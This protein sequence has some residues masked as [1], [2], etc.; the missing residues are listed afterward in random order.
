MLLQLT[1]IKNYMGS[2]I[3]CLTNSAQIS[4]QLLEPIFQKKTLNPQKALS[5]VVKIQS[6]W[7]GS[8]VRKY[9]ELKEMPDYRTPKSRLAEEQMESYVYPELKLQGV[10]CRLPKRIQDGGVYLGEMDRQEAP[11]ERNSGL[12]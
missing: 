12:A 1:N 7:R 10:H 4:E 9:Y 3:S 8:K 6:V 2:N 11:R 5:C